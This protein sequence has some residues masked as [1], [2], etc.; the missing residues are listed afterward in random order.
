VTR[1]KLPFGSAQRD[2]LLKL[3]DTHWSSGI[4]NEE[5]GTTLF[6]NK[7]L[8]KAVCQQLAAHGFLDEKVAGRFCIYTVNT[9]GQDK[10]NQLRSLH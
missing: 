10:A 4:W 2:V 3:T 6:E 9:V 1:R 7:A 8:T 5:S